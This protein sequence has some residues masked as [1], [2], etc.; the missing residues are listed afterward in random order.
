MLYK[1][2]K[3]G[4]VVNEAGLEKV[5]PYYRKILEEINKLYNDKLGDNLLSIYIRGSVSVGRANPGISDIDSIA[6]TKKEL[7][8]EELIWIIKSSKKLEKKYP[9]AGFFDLTVVSLEE[10]KN[11]KFT[12]FYLKMLLKY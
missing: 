9:K 5:Q 8:R 12:I 7:S 10:L 2:D 4:F 1:I 3:N 6:V 11:L